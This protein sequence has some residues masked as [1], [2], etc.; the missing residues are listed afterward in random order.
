MLAFFLVPVEMIDYDKIALVGRPPNHAKVDDVVL[1][2]AHRR[3]CRGIMQNIARTKS[4]GE[5]AVTA[6]SRLSRRKTIAKPSLARDFWMRWSSP[7]VS[8]SMAR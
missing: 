3:A 6:K 4:P 7:K 2:D 5:S 1:V 8:R